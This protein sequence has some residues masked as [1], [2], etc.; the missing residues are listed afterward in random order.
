ME[1]QANII[2]EV[3]NSVGSLRL[4]RPGSL[5]SLTPNLLDEFESALQFVAKDKSIKALVIAGEGR[6]FCTG[7]DLKVVSQL[8][9][10]WPEYVEFLYRLTEVFRSLEELPIPTIAQVQG[11][12]IAGGLEL[13]LCCDLTVAAEDAKIGDQHTN[14][15]LI[16][17]AGGIPRLVRRI[18]KQSALDILYSGRWL[19]GTEAAAKGIVLTAV[20]EVKL[21]DAVAEITDRLV[22]KSRRSFTAIK[23]V[24]RAGED[25]PLIAALNE[26]RAALLEYFSTSGDPREGVNAFLEKRT[27]IFKE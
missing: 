27:P 5:N 17:G 23:R 10:R 13:L 19:S 1:D 9:D 14:F 3:N 6:S 8:F 21:G 7:A 18:G 26:E 16:A 15:G 12:A 2:F 11:H 24:V 20:P 4:N 25:V 22:H